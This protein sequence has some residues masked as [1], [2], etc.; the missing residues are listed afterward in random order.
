MA[1]EV[2]TVA[3]IRNENGIVSMDVSVIKGKG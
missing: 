3:K 2:S 1:A